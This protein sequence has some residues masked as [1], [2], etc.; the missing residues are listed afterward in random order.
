MSSTDAIFS[1]V[2]AAAGAAAPLPSKQ[3]PGLPRWDMQALRTALE[4]TA[5]ILA[6]CARAPAPGPARLDTSALQQVLQQ[7][8]GT[9]QRMEMRGPT[10]LV[11]AMQAALLRLD[12]EPAGCTPDAVSAL[13]HACLALLEYLDTAGAGG[14]VA[15]FAPYRAVQALAGN[16][17]A[18]PA[19]LWPVA[20]C[21]SGSDWEHDTPA[22]AYGP[23]A[24]ALLDAGVLLLVKTGQPQ[25]AAQLRAACLGLGVAQ[26]ESG[27]R[28]FWKI[29]AGFFEALAQGLVMSDVYAKRTAS[30]V[31]LQYAAM[32]RGERQPPDR[33]TQELLFF[34][35]QAGPAGDRLPVLQAVRAAFGLEH[36]LPVDYGQPAQ[37]LR[38]VAAQA[39]APQPDGQDARPAAPPEGGP[40]DGAFK[41]IGGLR[42]P[43]ALYN[44]YLNAADEWSRCLD[45]SLQQ[46]ARAP[47]RAQPGEAVGFARALAASSATVGLQDLVR[48]ARVLERALLNVGS[49]GGVDAGQLA[50]LQAAVNEIHRLLHQ[51]AA[52][53][54]KPP[55]PAVEAALQQLRTARPG[56]GEA[57]AEPVKRR[58]RRKRT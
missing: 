8:A 53:F 7:A 41:H 33:L 22:L 11:Q 18:H 47:Q 50:A 43:L 31:L 37:G 9:L 21:R 30:R 10:L 38:R 34:C 20:H 4:G 35:A 29:A 14:P 49:R 26:A 16:D 55:L 13:E 2:P 54:L 57:A 36:H 51:F 46:W 28:S 44:V 58:A 56:L 52:G 45:A 17:K 1:P 27:A 39:L 19:D 48:L 42:I 32:A 5:G 12:Q 6:R 24:R 23:E 3:D 25:S 15:L 40:G